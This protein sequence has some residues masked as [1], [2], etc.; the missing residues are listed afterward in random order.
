MEMLKKRQGEYQT[1]V[2]GHA[3]AQESEKPGDFAKLVQDNINRA[4]KDQTNDRLSSMKN[5]FSSD[6]EAQKGFSV[7]IDDDDLMNAKPESQR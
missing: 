3:S 1:H 6:P 7:A 2:G 5:A 4:I